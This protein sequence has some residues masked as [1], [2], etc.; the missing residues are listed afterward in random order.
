MSVVVATVVR[1]GRAFSG[2]AAAGVVDDV[3]GGRDGVSRPFGCRA[4]M[5]AHVRAPGRS[6]AD[7]VT[8][9]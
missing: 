6:A 5:I 9:S 1:S 7:G 3:G 4:V 2:S 8:C